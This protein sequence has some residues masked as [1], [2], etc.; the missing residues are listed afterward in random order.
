[1][2]NDSLASKSPKGAFALLVFAGL[3]LLPFC[4]LAFYAH[5]FLDDFVLPRLM[6][7]RGWWTQL[8]DIY[9]SFS[10][11]YS[12]HLSM[13]LHP[14]AWGGL[15]AVKPFVFGFLVFLTGCFLFAGN[16]LVQGA[17]MPW[18]TRYA[19]GGLA[20]TVFLLLLGSPNE[21]FYWVT[22]ALMY[23]G[24]AACCLMLLGVVAHLHL[25]KPPTT[26]RLWWLSALVLAF[27]AP[28]FSEVVSCFVLALGIVLLPAIKR[29]EVRSEWLMLLG[30]AVLGSAIATLAPG[31]FLRQQE[32]SIE[33][34]SLLRTLVMAGG[35]MAYTLV[36]WLGNGLLVLLTLLVLPTMQQF[37]RVRSM[38]LTLLVRY[39]WRWP[40]WLVLGL[41]ICSIFS[42]LAIASPMPSRAR[43]LM[44]VF[45]VLSWFMSVFGYLASRQ[46]KGQAPLPSLPP[47]GQAVLAAL[48][49]LFSTSDHNI[50]LQHEQIGTPSNSVM[51]AYR[52]WLSG[53]ASQ[54]DQEEEARYAL[55]RANTSTSV[56]LPPLSVKPATIFW[57][58]ISA[59]PTLWGNQAYAQYFKKK[60]VWVKQ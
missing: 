19:T 49:L 5:S 38:P 18:P 32:K 58:D 8:R 27:L 47:Y 33:H 51:Q 54:Y 1:M 59:N 9:F 56:E 50:R 34:L 31:N 2:M 35:T 40:L 21:A 10:G 29:R 48:V 45:F 53:D 30:V 41:F 4:C 57:W 11:K 17:S 55:L 3:C 25:P 15:D 60:A 12:A 39:P 46:Q 7:E 44:L 43:N 52:D 23:M 26:R 28:G 36:S 14:L 20:L 6:Q 22:S 42:L 37:V 24:G 13:A 16:A